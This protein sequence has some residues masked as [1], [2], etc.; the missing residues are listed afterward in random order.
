MRHR[1]TDL[2]A[3]VSVLVSTVAMIALGASP[4]QIVSL[5]SALAVLYTVWRHGGEP[6]RKDRGQRS[7]SEDRLD[8]E[9]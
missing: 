9:A 7:A 4:D 1:V 2:C 8:P 6:V 5:S 3:F